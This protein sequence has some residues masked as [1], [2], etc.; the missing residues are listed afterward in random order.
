MRADVT[1]GAPDVIRQTSVLVPPVSSVMTFGSCRSPATA[2]AAMTPAAGP[3]FSICAG[4]SAAG[5]AG[6]RPPFDCMITRSRVT[7]S[8]SRRRSTAAR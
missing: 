2:T 7:P 4:R 6:R 3:E 8:D 5:P 1:S